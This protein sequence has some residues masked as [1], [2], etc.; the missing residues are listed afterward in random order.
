[1]QPRSD[2][3]EGHAATAWRSIGLDVVEHGFDAALAGLGY[4]NPN[5]KWR[6]RYVAAADD[7]VRFPSV[8]DPGGRTPLGALRELW[9]A[10]GVVDRL[11]AEQAASALSMIVGGVASTT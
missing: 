8:A 6:G 7:D 3:P 4:L 9:L 11:D 10:A 5:P 2:G 1:V